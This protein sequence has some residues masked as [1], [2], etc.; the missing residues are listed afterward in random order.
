MRKTKAFIFAVAFLTGLLFFALSAMAQEYQRIVRYMP[1]GITV[2][3]DNL[4][5]RDS[6]LA[7][8]CDLI[9]LPHGCK[10]SLD[11]SEMIDTL[12]ILSVFGVKCYRS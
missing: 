4:N 6:L 7:P 5:A 10:A 1:D 11:T 2:M 8:I 3:H 12:P 9:V